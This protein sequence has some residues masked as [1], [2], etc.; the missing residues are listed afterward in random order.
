MHSS[1]ELQ[2]D[3][4]PQ[5]PPEQ[6]PA[7]VAPQLAEQVSKTGST[8]EVAVTFVA[9]T[10]LVRLSAVNKAPNI[11]TARNAVRLK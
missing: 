9:E 2:Q 3:G 1:N 11:I 4:M 10:L 5:H 6:F 8:A 7:Q